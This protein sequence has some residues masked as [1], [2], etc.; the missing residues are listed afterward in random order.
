MKDFAV[1]VQLRSLQTSLSIKL[2]YAMTQLDMGNHEASDAALV[3][4]LQMVNRM[5]HSV[6]RAKVAE[7]QEKKNK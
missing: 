5:R 4:V 3:D 2:N 6:A 7:T 1:G